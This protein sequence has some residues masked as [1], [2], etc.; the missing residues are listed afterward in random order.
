MGM[1]TARFWLQRGVDGFRLDAINFAMHDPGLTDNPPVL[2]P[3]AVRRRPFDY[4]H[5]FYN[6]SQPGL[7]PFLENL[8]K[9]MRSFGADRFTVAEVGGEQALTEMKSFTAGS[10]RLNTSYGFDF[11]SA[12]QL[13]PGLILNVLG[14]WPG[15]PGK[16]AAGA[17]LYSDTR[18][19]LVEMGKYAGGAGI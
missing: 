18:V 15:T 11:L 2:D 5:H 14:Q 9:V 17:L 4:Q 10:T 1:D 12:E 19:C 13:S 7:I 16:L 3:G 8:S 6:Q